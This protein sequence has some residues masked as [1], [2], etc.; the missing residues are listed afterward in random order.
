LE[1]LV[2]FVQDLK[3]MLDDFA[4]QHFLK[5][6]FLFFHH[7]SGPGPGLRKSR[8]AKESSQ[9]DKNDQ[10]QKSLHANLLGHKAFPELFSKPWG[11]V[12]HAWQQNNRPETSTRY[13]CKN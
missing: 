7:H 6:E 2:A 5:I 12:P 8:W 11:G 3:S 10:E 4:F 9:K 1:K 13:H